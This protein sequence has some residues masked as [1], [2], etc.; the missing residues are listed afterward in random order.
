MS[1]INVALVEDDPEIRR[2][3]EVFLRKT[4]EISVV[5]LFCCA[6]DFIADF[7]SLNLDVVLM[8]ITL[9]GMTGI[10]CVAR[11]KPLQP[12]VQYLMCTIHEDQ[13]RTFAS[14][15]AGATGYIT[16]N[17]PPSR[18][19]EAIRDIYNG[20]SPMSAQIARM[21]VLTFRDRGNN[22]E[23]LDT[24]SHREQEIL[25][26]LAKGYQYKE[27]A[28]K[29]LISIETVRTYLRKIYEKLQVHSKVEAINKIF[30][31]GL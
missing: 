16:K 24:F 8:D 13:E 31:R 23:L 17:S 7:E 19:I 29:L 21:V 15:C 26:S 28:E 6:E 25:I 11:M 5:G 14:L 22:N 2:S 30:P 18:L 1:I 27:I 20:G 4:D 12:Q 3:M 9:P 10:E